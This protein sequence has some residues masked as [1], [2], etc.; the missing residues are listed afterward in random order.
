MWWMLLPTMDITGLRLLQEMHLHSIGH[1]KVTICTFC[2]KY[3]SHHRVFSK[4]LS[5]WQ[6][7]WSKWRRKKLVA[8][9]QL[10]SAQNR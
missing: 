4:I 1:G 9:E 10:A 6:K 2:F 8:K 7:L 5:R 3:K